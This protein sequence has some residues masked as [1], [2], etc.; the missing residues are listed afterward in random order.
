MA[1]GQDE[2]KI[3]TNKISTSGD[4]SPAIIAHN[5]HLNYGINEQ[6]VFGLLN[7][8]DQ[9]GL[10]KEECNERVEILVKQYHR[11]RGEPE[12]YFFE[13]TLS[14]DGRKHLGIENEKN[15]ENLLNWNTYLTTSG[16][17]SPAIIARGDVK[18]FYGMPKLVFE[19]IWKKL[20]NQRLS[21]NDL[22]NKLWESAIKYN[23]LNELLTKS[24]QINQ[25][26]DKAKKALEL[27]DLDEAEDLLIKS[28][29]NNL[30]A[31][32]KNQNA[33][34]LS[35]LNIANDYYQLGVLKELQFELLQAKSNFEKSI[36]Y[37]SLNPLYI[38]SLGRIQ[39]KVAE[40]DQSNLLLIEAL[41]Y[42][43]SNSTS[44]INLK[45]EIYL[46]LGLNYQAKDKFDKSIESIEKAI[47][48]REKI[49]D[50]DLKQIAAL[51]K[52]LALVWYAKGEYL[53]TIN[54]CNKSFAT[55]LKINQ[56]NG[57]DLKIPNSDFRRMPPFVKPEESIDRILGFDNLGIVCTIKGEYLKAIAYFEKYIKQITKDLGPNHPEVAVGYNRLGTVWYSM[58]EFDKSLHCF[59]NA[60]KINLSI[61]G[62]THPVV[63]ISYN[64]IGK[65]LLAKNKSD[66]A[67]IYHNK[68]LKI[69]LRFHNYYHSRIAE[70]YK[71]LGNICYKNAKYQEAVDLYELSF[72]IQQK[73]FNQFH[74]SFILINICLGKTWLKLKKYNCSFKHYSKAKEI[75]LKKYEEYNPQM[76]YIYYSLA[77]LYYAKFYNLRSISSLRLCIVIYEKVVWIM[78]HELKEDIALANI[79]H[80]LGVAYHSYAIW[81]ENQNHLET[82]I[83]YYGKSLIIKTNLLEPTHSSISYSYHELGN[84]YQRVTNKSKVKFF[85]VLYIC[86]VM[87]ANFA[88]F[89]NTF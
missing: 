49:A 35:K 70:T 69:N 81:T 38:K 60:K 84:A 61:Y 25:F 45:S 59:E 23:E 40:Y 53:N 29:N 46:L 71:Y 15:I 65:C 30:N 41:Q 8:M 14:S 18:I 4:Q 62:E 66:S 89:L 64:N 48:F 1:R 34:I 28:V 57:T 76:A 7:I 5:I 16:S 19:A 67:L 52:Q 78:E 37:D 24:K 50:K 32:S 85:S 22:E 73:I 51:Y 26:T 17:K 2:I 56:N 86:A 11:I 42:C 58:K 74:P 88:L 75:A 21:I 27:G 36:Q 63:A 3:D 6:V 54:Y 82:A 9:K 77:S 44:E 13:E 12:K 87:L 31:I 80:N 43:D 83:D 72:T 33:I 10:S 20:E 68:A 79:Y 47:Y 55:L 39:Y